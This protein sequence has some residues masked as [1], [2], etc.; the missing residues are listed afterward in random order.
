MDPEAETINQSPNLVFL[1]GS[2]C[3]SFMLVVDCGM[4]HTGREMMLTRK[5]IDFSILEKNR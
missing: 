4:F 5:S 1:I 3:L 2:E